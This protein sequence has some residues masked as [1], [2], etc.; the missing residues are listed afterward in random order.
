MQNNLGYTARSPKWSTAYKFP[1]EEVTTKLIDIIFTV[2]RTGKITPNAILEPVKVAGSTITRATLHN[3]DFIKEK[4]IKIGDIV[5]IRKAGDVI[6]EVASVKFDKRKEELPEFVMIKTC[7]VCNTLL[8]KTEKQAHHFC[9]NETCD[10]R[11]IEKLCH[12]VSRKAMNIDGLGERIIEDFYNF[13]YFKDIASI[14]DLNKYK[15]ELKELEGF[16]DKSINNILEAIDN[17]KNNSL[18]KLLFGLGIRHFGEKS[19]STIARNFPNIDL[20]INAPSEDIIKIKDVGTVMGLSIKDYFSKKEN[21]ILIE[22][23]KLHGLNMNYLG[24]QIINDEKFSDKKFVITGTISFMARDKIKEEIILRGGHVIDAIS[25]KIDALI[26]GDNPGSKYEKAKD[27]GIE[28][29]DEKTLKEK[30]GDNNE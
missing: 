4:D 12:F 20:L 24:K 10:A 14:Y 29:W 30:F 2:G 8:V 18:E 1:P 17:S 15:E 13:G 19:A 23:L 5:V 16:G 25:K 9:L 28:I 6:P 7:P 27:L 26:V 3:E 22:K 11:N 21:L